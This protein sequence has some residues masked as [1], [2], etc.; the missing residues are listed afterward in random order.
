MP[1]SGMAL[2][3]RLTPSTVIEPSGHRDPRHLGGHLDVQEPCVLAGG[4]SQHRADAVHMTLHQM[5]AQPVA[6]TERALEVHPVARA[7][8]RANR[9]RSSEVRTT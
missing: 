4:H 2:T 9:V 3:V 8:G 5:P 7:A 6:D 1:G